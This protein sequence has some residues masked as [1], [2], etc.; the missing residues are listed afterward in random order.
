MNCRGK[1]SLITL[2][3]ISWSLYSVSLQAEGINWQQISNKSLEI[4]SD[5]VGQGRVLSTYPS[6]LQTFYAHLFNWQPDKFLSSECALNYDSQQLRVRRMEF[7]E[8]Y[9]E[10]FTCATNKRFKDASASMKVM[11]NFSVHFDLSDTNHFRKVDFRLPRN[12]GGIVNV[13]GLLG[14]HDDQKTRPLVIIRM[15]VH[16]NI[17]EFVAERFIAKV[18]YEDFDFNFL[19]LENLTSEGYIHL[20]QDLAYGGMDEGL[21]TYL[22]LQDILKNKSLAKITSDVHLFGVSLGAPGVFITNMLDEANDHRIKTTT[23]FC[24][25]I[26][27]KTTTEKLLEPGIKKVVTDMWNLWRLQSVF[28]KGVSFSN[29]SW[30]RWFTDL[31]PQ[32]LPALMSKLEATRTQPVVALDQNI[33][34]PT[35]FAEFLKNNKSFYGM[36][37]FWSLYKNQKTPFLIV[38]TPQDALVPE[39]INSDLISLGT[40][41]GVFEKTQRI[42][43]D[44]GF[45]CGLPAEYSWPFIVN[46]FRIQWG[47]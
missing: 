3:I 39:D 24:P 28:Q 43:L 47:Q 41:P 8:F 34:M 31:K 32:L 40:Q 17:D 42:H 14:I 33:K 4:E 45:H 35:G 13:R 1:I 2:V 18:A 6:F 38:T 27:L 15:G 20:N 29:I 30:W 19:A 5:S 46:L 23:A 25:V 37:D 21:E 36:N 44:R 9:K 26:N 11:R 7:Q 16:G 22:V 12:G 10:N